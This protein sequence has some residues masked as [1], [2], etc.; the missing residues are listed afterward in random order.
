MRSSDDSNGENSGIVENK[1]ICKKPKHDRL[2]MKYIYLFAVSLG[3]SGW[4]VVNCGYTDR[5]K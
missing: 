3:L 5:V 2:C 4:L 1:G